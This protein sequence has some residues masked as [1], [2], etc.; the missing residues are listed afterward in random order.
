MT[1]PSREE[2][3]RLVGKRTALPGGSKQQGGNFVPKKAEAASSPSPKREN[4]LN[5][6]EVLAR[7]EKEA[8]LKRGGKVRKK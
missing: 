6:R 1:R 4:F 8:G 3:E 2:A 5:P 7:R